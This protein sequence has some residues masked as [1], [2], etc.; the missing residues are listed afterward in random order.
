MSTRPKSSKKSG[1]ERASDIP[2]WAK[3]QK[4]MKGE[5]GKDFAKRIC[6][7]KYGEGNYPIGPGSEY[8]QIKKYGEMLLKEVNFDVRL[9]T[10]TFL[11][12]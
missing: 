7:E 11:F 1:K 5:S 9:L 8:N 3:G 10:A 6:D 4:P 2:S 12:D